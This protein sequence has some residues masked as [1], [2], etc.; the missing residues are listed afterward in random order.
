M[1]WVKAN[2]THTHILFT[3]S[4]A[5]YL[6]S[7]M[8]DIEQESFWVIGLHSDQNNLPKSLYFFENS[9]FLVIKSFIKVDIHKILI[10]FFFKK[11]YC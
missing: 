7:D 4:V 10:Q 5:G 8:L 2:K 9:M 1:N 6:A 11:N 3:M